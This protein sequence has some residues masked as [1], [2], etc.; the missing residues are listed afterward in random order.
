MRV[1]SIRDLDTLSRHERELLDEL[2]RDHPVLQGRELWAYDVEDGQR[3]VIAPI[4]TDIR[5]GM[6][7]VSVGFTVGVQAAS[8]EGKLVEIQLAGELA[9]DEADSPAT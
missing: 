4:S 8:S 1:R 7:V 5:S 6:R 2:L 3:V 9:P